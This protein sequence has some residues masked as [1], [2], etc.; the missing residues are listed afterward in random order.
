MKPAV[1]KSRGFCRQGTSAPMRAVVAYRKS[2]G[3]LI[4]LF[5]HGAPS[6]AP[7]AKVYAPDAPREHLHPNIAGY[8]HAVD[9]KA[10]TAVGKTRSGKSILSVEHGKHA[11]IFRIGHYDGSAF[12]VSLPRGQAVTALTKAHKD[13][14]SMDH[15]D[16]AKHH[17]NAAGK[18]KVA[19]LAHAHMRLASAHVM[20]AEAK[21]K[22]EANDGRNV[23]S[24]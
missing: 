17:I 18:T 5:P 2:Q 3:K 4:Q 23:K 13:Y 15:V 14:D 9:E 6:K 22:K 7:S 10:G 11:K 1:S 12:G 19:S 20:T 16:A 21:A 24:T 8:P